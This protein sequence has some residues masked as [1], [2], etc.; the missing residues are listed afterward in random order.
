MHFPDNPRAAWQDAIE[1]IEENSPGRVA[2]G[3]WSAG[4]LLYVGGHADLAIEVWK[5][6]LDPVLFRHLRPYAP[7]RG[8]R[9]LGLPCTRAR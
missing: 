9:L 7:F 5:R 4:L 6:I 8:A 1:A 2:F 3:A